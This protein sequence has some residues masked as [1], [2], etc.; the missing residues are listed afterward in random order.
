MPESQRCVGILG[1]GLIGGS[2]A[3]AYHAA[4][5]RVLALDTDADTLAIAMI[6]TVDG[7]LDAPGIAECDLIILAAY[8][9]ACVDWLES[10]APALGELGK[11]GPLVMDAAGV[12]K[13]LCE[14]CFELARA[15][16]FSFCGAHPMAGTEQS[17]YARSNAELFKGAPMVLVPPAL[18]T[19]PSSTCSTAPIRF[20]PPSGSAPS[21]RRRR[22][23][24]TASS[25]SPAS[26]PTSYRTHT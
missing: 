11:T 13:G 1:L 15:H 17:G 4:G 24:T 23:T 5:W 9:A 12:K 6:D 25:P 18:P 22:K 20:S 16:G 26:S 3:R 10:H 8:P 19:P 21:R 2:F 7:R 14:R